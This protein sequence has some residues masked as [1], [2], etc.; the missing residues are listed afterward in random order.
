LI[1]D[2]EDLIILKVLQEEG[3]ISYA[4]LSRRTGIPDSTI[5]DKIERMVSRGIIKKF[6]A[7]LDGKRVG[8]DITAIVGVETGAKLYDHVAKALC[9][10]PEVLEVYG[11]TA[12]FDLIIKI[13]TSTKESLNNLLNRIR[14]VDGVEDIYVF[15]ILEIFKEEHALP[16]KDPG[17]L[18]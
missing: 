6:V 15:L 5:H 8:V 16:L 17:Q 3:R 18:K 4:E 9:E 13:R 14:R 11:A 2:K 10:I 12:E 7:I 1:L